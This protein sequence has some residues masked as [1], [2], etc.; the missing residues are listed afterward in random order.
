MSEFLP[1][2]Y[3]E[4]KIV[5]FKDANI[6]IATHALHYGTAAFG[7]MRATVD[8]KTKQV[9][10][11]RLDDHC[12][13]LSS[14]AKLLG[15]SIKADFIKKKILEF[16]KAN[17]CKDNYYI[18]P[19]V[20]VS[21]LGIAPRLHNVKYDFLIYGLPMGDYLDKGGIKVCF[22]SWV[23]GEDRSLPLRGKIAGTYVTSALSKTEAHERGFDEA[24]LLNSAGKIAEASAMNLFIVRGNKLIT[25]SVNQDILE[26]ITRDSVI[27]MA[28]DFNYEIIERP[29]DKSELL[30]ADE[31]FLS[32]TAA[33]V[34]PIKKV[35]GY[36]L[37]E[38][39]PIT[40][41]LSEEFSK[42]FTDP[43]SK[44]LSWITKL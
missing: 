35:E 14:S 25:P 2:A 43:K 11:F 22:S 24:I 26:G 19:L 37:P 27:K 28:R 44:Y 29:V 5:D 3:F 7:G 4:G 9:L 20:Y 39:N 6:S 21:D 10:L 12:K 34:T 1:K 32:G 36:N 15:Y 31:A 38:N 40:Q 8:P 17:P 42:I 18:R 13:R 23:R 30:I 41:K 16:V 33:Q